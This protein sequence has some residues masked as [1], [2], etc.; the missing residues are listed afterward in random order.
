MVDRPTWNCGHPV[1]P[2]PTTEEARLHIG[3]T[4][5]QQ[6]WVYPVVTG[7]QVDG[8]RTCESCSALMVRLTV[9]G[10]GDDGAIQLPDILICP[11]HFDVVRVVDEWR[12]RVQRKN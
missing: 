8:L 7:A 10:L 6:V 1:S 9:G 4:A 3:H 11:D 5:D 12:A 2:H